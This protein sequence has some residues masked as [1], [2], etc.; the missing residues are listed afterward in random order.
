[1]PVVNY[2]TDLWWLFYYN[3]HETLTVIVSNV[4]LFFVLFAIRGLGHG[5]GGLVLVL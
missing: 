2:V 1:M 3:F 4:Y 5:L